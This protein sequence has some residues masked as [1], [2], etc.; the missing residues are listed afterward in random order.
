MQ[1]KC[2]YYVL[3]FSQSETIGV[4]TEIKLKSFQPTKARLGHTLLEYGHNGHRKNRGCREAR[5]AML[6]L[7]ILT[8]N[9]HPQ[10]DNLKVYAMKPLLNDISEM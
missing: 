1:G 3:K 4:F 9:F 7:L 10:A 5:T 8:Y 2:I 6:Q